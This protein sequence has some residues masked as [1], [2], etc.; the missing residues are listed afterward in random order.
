MIER[1]RTRN[2]WNQGQ[3]GGRKHQRLVRQDPQKPEREHAKRRR[4]E[5]AYYSLIVSA[6]VF[7]FAVKLTTLSPNAITPLITNAMAFL[8][9]IS[10][11]PN[12]RTFSNSPVHHPYATHWM[13]A[14]GDM[15]MRRSSG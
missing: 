13:N 8:P 12:L 6:L 2:S 4:G 5:S 3:I 7:L 11:A 10:L 1:E 14:R 9:S 15:R